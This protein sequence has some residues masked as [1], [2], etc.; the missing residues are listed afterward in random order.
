[1]VDW[2]GRIAEDPH[3]QNGEALPMPLKSAAMAVRMYYRSAKQAACSSE[4]RG[5]AQW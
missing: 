4:S 2:D 3:E 5:V 1:M